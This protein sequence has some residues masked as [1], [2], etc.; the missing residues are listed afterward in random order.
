[1]EDAL[2]AR[3][4]VKERGHV[5]DKIFDDRQVAQW[6]DAQC[7]CLGN[8]AHMCAARPARRSIDHHR[9]RTTHADAAGEAICERRF[10]VLLDPRHDVE[11]RLTGLFWHDVRFEAPA[12]RR[13]APDLNLKVCV[14]TLTHVI[15]PSSWSPRRA[16]RRGRLRRDHRSQSNQSHR[17]LQTGRTWPYRQALRLAQVSCWLR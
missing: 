17:H 11:H 1:M 14:R 13:S 6:L 8:L 10:G 7:V 2:G 16:P 9:A 15:R 4:F 5:G 12:I 3:P